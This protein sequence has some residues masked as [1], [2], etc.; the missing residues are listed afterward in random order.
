MPSLPT[1]GSNLHPPTLESRLLTTGPPGKFL[2][3]LIINKILIIV[4]FSPGSEGKESTCIKKRKKKKKEK[5]VYVQCGRP[6]VKHLGLEGTLEKKMAT[7]YSI[8]A[9]KIPWMEEPGGLQSMG[10]QRVGHD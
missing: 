7:H 6:G 9:W 1:Q 4:V 10:S 8:L 2:I 3:V 5:R